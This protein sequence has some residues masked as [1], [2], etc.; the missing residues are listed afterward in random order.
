MNWIKEVSKEVML[1][2]GL[3]GLESVVE[4]E[5]LK[6][7]PVIDAQK[8]AEKMAEHFNKPA[9]G[10]TGQEH[11]LWQLKIEQEF[12]QLITDNM[13]LDNVELCEKC[14]KK[15]NDGFVKMKE[16]ISIELDI[17]WRNGKA[18]WG[19]W[20]LKA[21]RFGDTKGF[22]WEL[23][24]DDTLIDENEDGVGSQELAQQESEKALKRI[25]TGQK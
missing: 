5:I 12:A 24:L 18:E 8:I 4:R 13:T 19:R 11:R 25:I 14:R 2:L 22:C 16:E 21:E 3:F 15:I 1:E 17:Q 20:T 7:A 9:P 23:Y 10:I 6:H